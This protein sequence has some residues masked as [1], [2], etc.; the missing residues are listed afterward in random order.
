MIN[1]V[2]VLPDGTRIP[3]EPGE[4]VLEAARRYG[5]G[6]N[7]GCREGGCGGCALELAAGIVTYPKTVAQSVLSD[8]DRVDGVC[9]PCRAVPTTD[10]V[11]KLNRVHRLGRGPF[12]DRLAQRALKKAGR[13]LDGAE[14]P[15]VGPTHRTADP[16][17]RGRPRRGAEHR[18]SVDKLSSTLESSTTFHER[19]ADLRIE[20]KEESAEGVVAL[21]LTDPSGA[22][23]PEWSPGAHIDLVLTD[24]VTRQYSLCSS[25]T[26]RRSYRVGVLRDPGSRGGSQ[27][28]HDEL[29]AGGTVQVRGPRNHFPFLDAPEYVFVAGGIGITPMLPMIASA[30]AVGARWELHYGG[31]TRASMGFLDELSA[32]GDR[33]TVYPQEEVGHI[34]LGSIL[35]EPRDG[36]LVYSC[37]PGPLLDAMESS[38]AH[39]P[40]GSL[41]I[42]RFAAK[43][44]AA[45]PGALDTF[46]VVCQR[47]GVNLKIGPD[48]TI[49]DAAQE[50]GLKVLASCRAGVCGTC[51][52]DV[53]DGQ[54][55]HR[56]S[57]LSAAERAENEFMLVCIS[58]SL[59]PRLVLDL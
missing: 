5:Y 41:H 17:R 31:R 42:E 33:V 3:A 44:V 25:T 7:V 15:V 19:E 24:S 34:P 18:M 23:L 43:P 40:P 32:Y 35:A 36:A 12:S 30:E 11:I 14:P 2:T 54:P 57:V 37:G 39:W 16:P 1:V 49:L 22:E 51:E 13:A 48:Q 50:A 27:F 53:I 21:T 4:T 6:L 55:D 59:S 8:S 56:D 10:V 47:S 26:D 38:T 52:V 29:Q 9:L 45:S 20:R 58:R 28:V 46:E